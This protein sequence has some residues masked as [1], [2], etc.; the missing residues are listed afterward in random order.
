MQT[1]PLFTMEIIRNLSLSEAIEI[2]SSYETDKKLFIVFLKN[3]H[4]FL[5][6][7]AWRDRFSSVFH[8]LIKQA[9]STNQS[10][11]YI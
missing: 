9:F 11:R 5:I 10:A 1:G 6:F 2:T 8:A 4:Y 7:I 3:M